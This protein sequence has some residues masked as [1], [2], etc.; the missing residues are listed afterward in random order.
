[1]W[2]AFSE[3]YWSAWKVDNKLNTLFRL[4]QE[5][6]GGT[7]AG[8][9]TITEEGKTAYEKYLK[10]HQSGAPVAGDRPTLD[11]APQSIAMFDDV[12]AL[13][14]E[15]LKL[16]KKEKEGLQDASRKFGSW[17][18]KGK[19]VYKDK[20]KDNENAEWEENLKKGINY[21]RADLK[22][23]LLCKKKMFCPA[24]I[25]L[26]DPGCQPAFEALLSSLHHTKHMP[27]QPF[28]PPKYPEEKKRISK[29]ANRSARFVDFV[30]KKPG[31]YQ[32]MMIDSAIELP[33]EIKPV[34]R[35][36]QNPGALEE[37][38]KKQVMGHLA[39]YIKQC[40]EFKAHGTPSF[41]TGVIGTLAYIKVIQLHLVKHPT[42]GKFDLEHKASKYLPLISK[43]HFDEWWSKHDDAWKKRK[44]KQ[45]KELVKNLYGDVD[46]GIIEG[47]PKG[48]LALWKMKNEPRS[49]FFGPPCKDMF[50]VDDEPGFTVGDVLGHGACGLVIEAKRNDGD[51]KY[52]FKTSALSSDRHLINERDVLNGLKQNGA[53]DRHQDFLSVLEKEVKLNLQLGSLKKKVDALLLSPKGVPLT[54]Y[55]HTKDLLRSFKTRSNA[56]KIVTNT[57]EKALKHMHGLDYVHNDISPKNMIAISTGNNGDFT[58]CL[59]DFGI[60]SK[61]G[62]K[63]D[64]CIG[65]ALYM[66]EDAFAAHPY[67][68][69]AKKHHDHRGLSLTVNT[70]LSGGYP[71]WNMKGF[72]RAKTKN[73]DLEMTEVLEDRTKQAAG[74]VK[75]SQL[76]ADIKVK[77][78]DWLVL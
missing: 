31:Q 70:I 55:L 33:I 1:M 39:K 73:N 42:T 32:L 23:Q 46:E 43:E 47:I 65:T 22:G 2:S 52:V 13:S 64:F 34:F 41:A 37:Q 26:E 29:G 4:G 76:E 40:F 7:I 36:G 6:R 44:N 69:E 63:P 75:D 68:C 12:G 60:A 57:M 61:I 3:L 38:C 14:V 16:G 67:G 9:T 15:T 59:I 53:S 66:H 48:Y 51:T 19:I 45:Y 17:L 74:I 11:G 58:V 35:K 50:N 49:S 25:G 78:I 10:H 24:M 30:V 20:K 77:L 72:P 54:N 18:A 21:L 28:S 71:V 5:S 8:A 62:H 27:K 56:A